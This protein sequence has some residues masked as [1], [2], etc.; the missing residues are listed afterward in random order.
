MGGTCYKGQNCPVDSNTWKNVGY[1]PVD[2]RELI[3]DFTE[4]PSIL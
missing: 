2:L 4:A 1:Y 3:V